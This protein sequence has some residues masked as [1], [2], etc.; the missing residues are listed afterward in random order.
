MSC[1]DYAF[2]R[3]CAR[4]AWLWIN[5]GLDPDQ[6]RVGIFHSGLVLVLILFDSR[7]NS[8]LI[9]NHGKKIGSVGSVLVL[10]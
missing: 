8:E 9:Q 7:I 10:F 4:Q 1:C 3:C 6:I 5:E 2:A